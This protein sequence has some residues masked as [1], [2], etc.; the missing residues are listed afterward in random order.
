MVFIKINLKT[1][2][3]PSL[4]GFP[5][6]YAFLKFEVSPFKTIVE[7]RMKNFCFICITQ[8]IYAPTIWGF[9][10]LKPNS[11]LSFIVQFW[12]SRRL[13]DNARGNRFAS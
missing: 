7:F 5:N 3:G 8:D 11:F 1:F 6:L 9:L 12:W 4:F 2:F 10:L 13:Y